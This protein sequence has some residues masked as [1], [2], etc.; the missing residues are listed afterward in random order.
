MLALYDRTL[1]AVDTVSSWIVMAAMAILTVVVT[2][3][4][5]FRYV[6]NESLDWGWDV[7]RL[8]F[9]VTVLL[10]IPLA[11]ARNA[12]V[13]VDMVVE[14]LGLRPRRLIYRANAVLMAAL[15]LLVAYYAVVLAHATWDQRLPGLD[16]SVGFFYVA[17]FIAA[18]HSVLHLV[19]WLHRGGPPPRVE[20]AP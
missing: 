10:A 13:G 5:F 4:V 16:L 17:L 20:S 6:L 2:V 12:H 7:P 9:I 18:V 19:R 14:L 15:M 3:Q 1:S 11:L 8:C